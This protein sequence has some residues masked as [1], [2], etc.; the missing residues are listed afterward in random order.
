MVQGQVQ[1]TSKK[2]RGVTGHGASRGNIHEGSRAFRGTRGI[3]PGPVRG[4]GRE[5]LI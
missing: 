2:G 4:E 1:R 3:E 5:G